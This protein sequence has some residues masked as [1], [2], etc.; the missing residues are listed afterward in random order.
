MISAELCA[1]MTP[2]KLRRESSILIGTGS[3]SCLPDDRAREPCYVD[4][5]ASLAMPPESKRQMPKATTP[6][7]RKIKKIRKL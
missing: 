6:I 5:A 7:A 3:S 1:E 2:A 4:A